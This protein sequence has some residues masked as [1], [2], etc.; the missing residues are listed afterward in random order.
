M[1]KIKELIIEQYEFEKHKQNVDYISKYMRKQDKDELRACG[2]ENF[3][4]ALNIS[5]GVADIAFIVK[6]ENSEPLCIFG[7]S[8][9]SDKEL[10]TPVWFIGTDELDKYKKEFLYHSKLII[11]LWK[12]EFGDL[13]NYVHVK[14]TKSIRWLKWLGAELSEPIFYPGNKSEEL[15]INFK[16]RGD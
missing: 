5:L 6:T 15:F 1:A 2:C 10:G 3:L 11:D 9:I 7:V 12:K 4:Q 13:Y 14:N 8:G 16:I